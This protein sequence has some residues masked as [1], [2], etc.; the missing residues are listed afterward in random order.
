MLLIIS[1]IRHSMSTRP[2]WTPR[3]IDGGPTRGDARIGKFTFANAVLNGSPTLVAPANPT[4]AIPSNDIMPTDGVWSS[5]KGAATRAGHLA[6]AAYSH[7]KEHATKYAREINERANVYEAKHKAHVDAHTAIVT[8]MTKHG[9]KSP[10]HAHQL[11]HGISQLMSSISLGSAY[12]PPDIGCGDYSSDLDDTDAGGWTRVH[13]NLHLLW[14][15]I[16]HHLAG[17]PNEDARL[18]RGAAL[19]ATATGISMAHMNAAAENGN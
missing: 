16:H 14:Y 4:S 8:E 2:R 9:A 19:E 15:K 5:I 17:A 11:M 12:A 10:G 6:H 18:N 1:Y 13:D 7:V 3:K